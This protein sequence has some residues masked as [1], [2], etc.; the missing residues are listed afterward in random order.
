MNNMHASD[1]PRGRVVSNFYFFSG[2]YDFS[3]HFFSGHFFL[4]TFRKKSK[5]IYS[6]CKIFEN[7]N[8]VMIKD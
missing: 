6:T 4:V 2:F 3:G 8:V 7:I 1:Y 5:S